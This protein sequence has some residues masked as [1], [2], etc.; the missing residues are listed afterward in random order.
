MY[1]RIL[2]AI[3]PSDARRTA[4]STAGEMARLTGAKVHVVHVVA[5]TVAA[6]AVLVLEEEDEGQ[7]ILKESLAALR[8]LGVQAD[9]HLVRGLTPEVP[10]AISA[11]AEDFKADLMIISPHHRNSVSAFFNPRVSDAVAHGSRID[12]LLVSEGEAKQ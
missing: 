2:V 7:A 8:D 10:A 3:D 11:A 6:G 9:G 5:S 1:E 4:L 12:I